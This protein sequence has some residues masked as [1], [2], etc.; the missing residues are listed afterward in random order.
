[1]YTSQSAII[2]NSIEYSAIF[3]SLSLRTLLKMFF[4]SNVGELRN[5]FNACWE[6]KELLSWGSSAT[7]WWGRGLMISHSYY[8]RRCE[9]RI[10]C[11]TAW[12]P[13]ESSNQQKTLREFQIC[14]TLGNVCIWHHPPQHT[15]DQ[16]WECFTWHLRC[17]RMVHSQNIHKCV[18][19]FLMF[20]K[21]TSKMTIVTRSSCLTWK[22]IA[23]ERMHNCNINFYYFFFGECSRSLWLEVKSNKGE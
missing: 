3:V 23:R 7:Y 22:R 17:I 14:I 16:R 1:M 18:C 10:S 11:V 21:I 19:V 20:F 9:R 5:P 13:P 8:S 15:D 6:R 12:C 4:F 2:A